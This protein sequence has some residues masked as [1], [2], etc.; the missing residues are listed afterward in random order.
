MANP[1]RVVLHEDVEHLGKSGDVVRVRPGHARNFLYPRGL[2]VPATEQ[3][4][5]RVDDLKRTAAKR[6]EQA[7]EEAR[8]AAQRLEATAVKLE[9]SVGDENKMYGSVTARDIG[10]AFAGAGVEL[11]R[12]K[13]ELKEPIKQLG[14]HEVPVRLH[15]DVIAKLRV[16]VIK[17]V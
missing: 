9:R 14:L 6:A 11:D 17:K 5:S 8:Q 3:N 16:E 13:I 1:I 15:A 10:E 4:L 12:R 7:L 2:A